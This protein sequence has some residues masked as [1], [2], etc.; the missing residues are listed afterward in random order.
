M[1]LVNVHERGRLQGVHR[2]I[3]V[4]RC[5]DVELTFQPPA[6]RSNA[7][8]EQGKAVIS[9]ASRTSSKQTICRGQGSRGEAIG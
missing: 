8:E 6:N 5:A 4:E 1:S 7:F 2:S 3:G 9:L